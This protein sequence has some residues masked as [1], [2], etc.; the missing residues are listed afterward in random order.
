M[1]SYT[2]NDRW[3]ANTI[4]GG[5]G[6]AKA[7]ANSKELAAKNAVAEAATDIGQ[8]SG[9]YLTAYLSQTKEGGASPPSV[10]QP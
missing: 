8:L 3:T 6:E 2:L 10:S 1:Y 7:F 4:T 9:K 5:S